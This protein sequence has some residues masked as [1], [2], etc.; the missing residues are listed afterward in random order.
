MSDAVERAK[1]ILVADQRG[2][3]RAVLE[4]VLGRLGYN[5]TAVDSAAA[6]REALEPG[7]VDLII[8]GSTVAGEQADDMARSLSRPDRRVI[9]VD[10]RPNVTRDMIGFIDLT[11]DA[12]RGIGVRV[13]EIVFLANDLLYSRSGIPRRKRRVYGGFPARFEYE[14][15]TVR[16]SIYNLSAEGAFVET[17]E[18]P[19]TG[20]DVTVQFDLPTVG[21][22]SVAARVTWRVRPDQTQGL[23]SPPGM[24]V[25]F[26][27]V[28]SGDEERIRSFVASGGHP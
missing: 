18:P 6:L 8:L 15:Q 16:G 1:S 2:P 13:P 26:L 3:E 9:L 14:G 4:A 11:E 22:F 24:G 17:E 25:R 12:F 10:S 28:P 5:V 19:S 20:S 27:N 21:P 7:P 23:R